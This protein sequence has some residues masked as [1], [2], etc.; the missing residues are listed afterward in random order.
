M[1]AATSHLTIIAVM[2][3]VAL[4]ARFAMLDG[5]ILGWVGKRVEKM[6]DAYLRKPIGTCERCMVSLWGTAAVVC[7]D[8]SPALNAALWHVVNV[9]YGDAPTLAELRLVATLP[10][11]WLAAVGLQEMFDR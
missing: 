5:H 1:D 7:L 2:A 3:L 9:P 10:V 4:G 11:Y 8:I 6:E